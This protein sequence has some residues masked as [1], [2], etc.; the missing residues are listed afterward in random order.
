[1]AGVQ[2]N[3]AMPH[4]PSA[5]FRLRVVQGGSIGAE[6][7]LTGPSI[8]IGRGDSND[9]ILNDT[10]CS[11]NHAEL[12]LQRGGY[13][14]RDLGSRNGVYVNGERIQ[15]SALKE[16]DTIQVGGTGFQYYVLGA[17]P[18]ARGAARKNNGRMR[19]LLFVLGG[20][21]LGVIALVAYFSNRPEQSH[22]STTS[23]EVVALDNV[24]KEDGGSSG[25]S[26]GIAVGRNDRTAASDQVSSKG[27][28]KS[29]GESGKETNK[30]KSREIFLEAQRNAEAGRLVD[31]MRGFERALELDS[32]CKSCLSRLTRLRKQRDKEIQHSMQTGKDYME[33]GRYEE[34]A[35]TFERVL[36]LDPDPQSPYHE[37]AKRYLA[38]S[39]EKGKEARPF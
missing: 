23:G 8:R 13:V 19:P 2:S 32:D 29:N 34:A 11:R 27:R 9:I 28:K 25:S 20:G 39:K 35:A 24:L 5:E 18:P 17:R 37:N 7:A 1:M 26:G 38:E 14:V 10:N 6:F 15:Q 22:L 21:A 31:A 33:V 12:V 16:G 4:T 30:R 36:L 3:T